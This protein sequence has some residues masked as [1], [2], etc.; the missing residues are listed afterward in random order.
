MGKSRNRGVYRIIQTKKFKHQLE[1]L[2]HS[3]PRMDE[4]KR[5]MTWFLGRTPRSPL[6]FDLQG[7][8]FL[9]VTDQLPTTSIPKIRI[10]YHVNDEGRVVKLISIGEHTDQP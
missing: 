8:Y 6:C 7:G 3:H 5:A 10:V 2:Y 4:F 9:W 1:V